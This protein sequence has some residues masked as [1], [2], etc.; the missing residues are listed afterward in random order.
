MPLRKAASYSKRH[1]TPYTRNSRRK[2]KAY[3]RT[4]PYS[5]IVRFTFGDQKAFRAGQHKFII[6]LV[7]EQ[8]VLV[9]DNA[10]EACRMQ[11][12]K[13]LEEGAPGEY[14]LAVKVQPHHFLRNNKTSGVA[15]ADRLST[16]MSHSFGVIE[17]R[18]AIVPKGKDIFFVSTSSEK[19][20]KIAR[21]TLQSLKAKIPGLMK[22]LFEDLTLKKG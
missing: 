15:G 9:R 19:A 12:H 18:A 20:T 7:A 6:K 14:F 1:F 3:I 22:V 13:L 21:E 16:G 10:L 17:G 8:S 11:L 4:V 2:G 5:K